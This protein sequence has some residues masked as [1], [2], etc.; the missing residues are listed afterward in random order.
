MSKNSCLDLPLV[1]KKE[2]SWETVRNRWDILSRGVDLTEASDCGAKIGK[3]S[4]AETE[5]TEPSF[6]AFT[7]YVQCSGKVL[8]W[9][10]IISLL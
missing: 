10:I 9:H 1:Q 2:R 4:P 5:A 7:D 3:S 6:F 8:K